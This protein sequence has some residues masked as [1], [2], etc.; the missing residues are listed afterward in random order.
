MASLLTA[1]RTS[2]SRQAKDAY[3]HLQLNSQTQILLPLTQ[4]KEVVE[5]NLDRFTPI[6]NMPSFVLGLL[7]QRSQVI[8]T[9]DL[10]DF[11][12]IT[13]LDLEQTHYP[14]TIIRVG[15]VALGLATEKMRG[16]VHTFADQI[17]SPVGTVEPAIIPYLRG[18]LVQ[19]PDAIFLVLDPS[20]LLANKRELL[21]I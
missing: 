11:F 19:P 10:A 15:K 7:N 16:I 17:Q 18:C 8:W 6:P 13:P 21:G 1:E 14:V 20:S 5:V 2:L 12:N 9:I 3:L 4:I